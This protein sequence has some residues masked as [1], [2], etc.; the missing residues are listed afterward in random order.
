MRV[1]RC[2]PRASAVF[3]SSAVEGETGLAD[4]A[5]R[6]MKPLLAVSREVLAQPRSAGLR[7]SSAGQGDGRVARFAGIGSHKL[8]GGASL[9]PVLAARAED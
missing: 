1:R 2:W 9:R 4:R 3:L 6:T 7:F 8:C 5:L